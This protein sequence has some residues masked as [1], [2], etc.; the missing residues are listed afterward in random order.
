M[1]IAVRW[2]SCR[3][4]R[5]RRRPW[6]WRSS[7]ARTARN[8]TLPEALRLADLDRHGEAF[9]LATEAERAI[10]GDPVLA[11]LWPRISRTSTVTSTPDGAD[12]SF[13]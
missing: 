3:G 1:T 13:G 9:L 11:A 5:H 10:P 4:R 2:P 7:G 12:V 8:V 6:A